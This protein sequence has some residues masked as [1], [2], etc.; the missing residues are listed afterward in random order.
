MD[1]HHSGNNCAGSAAIA[2]AS[3]YHAVPRKKAP[4]TFLA[5]MP[6]TKEERVN[7]HEPIIVQCLHD[8][9][10]VAGRCVINGGRP[11]R[12]KVLHMQDVESAGLQQL[13]DAPIGFPRPHCT[14]CRSRLAE[15]LYSAIVFFQKLYFMPMIAQEGSFSDAALVL[16][17]GDQISVVQHQDPHCALSLVPDCCARM[18]ADSDLSARLSDAIAAEY[19]MQLLARNRTRAAR[20]QRAC[21]KRREYLTGWGRVAAKSKKIKDQPLFF[22]QEV[23]PR[24]QPR[25][26]YIRTTLFANPAAVKTPGCDKPSRRKKTA[27]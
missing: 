20:N 4:Q 24:S 1:S 26:P 21:K 15:L 17:A 14:D 19:S 22:L 12:K 8:R 16:P 3:M 25:I 7:A 9:N 2:I 5:D 6:V 10:M 13:V 11:Q 27:F 18:K 23:S